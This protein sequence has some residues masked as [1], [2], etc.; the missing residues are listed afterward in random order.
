MRRL[1]L[2]LVPAILIAAVGARG[3]TPEPSARPV[4]GAPAVSIFYYPWYGTATEDGFYEHWGQ[5]G[6]RPPDDIAA[7]FYPARGVYSS[8]DTRVVDAQL[9][10]IAAAGV[11]EIVVSWWGTAS[12][13]NARLPTILDAAREHGLTVAIHLEPYPGRSAES[14]AADIAY[15]R[16]LGVDTFYLYQPQDLPPEDWAAMNAQLEGVTVYAQTGLA[17]FARKGGFAGLYTYDVLTHGASS[18]GRICAAARLNGLLCAPSVGPGYDARRG[19]GDLRIKL[20]RGGATYD[21]MWRAAIAAAADRV[22]ITSYNEWHE[23][24]QIEAAASIAR[25]GAYRYGTYDGAYGR[26]GVA[27]QNAY[28]ERTA[29][30]SRAFVASSLARVLFGDY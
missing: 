28:L 13:E 11:G 7:G 24:T 21:A 27:A 9:A 20:R 8:S 10:E 16:G 30:W 12:T 18:I 5:Y 23:G 14:T 26:R 3:A 22:T 19:S 29:H 25:R 6:H 4:V 2:L 15:L 17:G 1:A